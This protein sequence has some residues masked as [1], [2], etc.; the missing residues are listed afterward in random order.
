MHSK[1]TKT[2]QE[3]TTLIMTEIRKHPECNNITS[4]GITRP[5]QQAPH[6]P[7]WAPAWTMNGPKLAPPIA[8][9]IARRFQ[10]EF[11]LV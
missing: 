6:H 7:N 2:T 1:P 4:V 9:E 3:L 5:L 8:Q 10:N 11:D